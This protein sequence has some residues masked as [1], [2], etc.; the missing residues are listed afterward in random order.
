MNKLNQEENSN[1]LWPVQALTNEISLTSDSNRHST[2]SNDFR[3]NIVSPQPVKNIF[4][5]TKTRSTRV[6]SLDSS[7][8]NINLKSYLFS[9]NSSLKHLLAQGGELQ[10]RQN[11]QRQQTAKGHGFKCIDYVSLYHK[12]CSRIPR[13]VDS[14]YS[15]QTVSQEKNTARKQQVAASELTQ[16]KAEEKWINKGK[17]TDKFYY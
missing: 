1:A 5:L 16:S 8:A 6:K 7:A 3:S 14:N 13:F 4:T 17:Q 11:N 12:I 2:K 15:S 10:H 9:T